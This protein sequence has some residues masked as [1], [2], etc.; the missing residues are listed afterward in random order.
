[1]SIF[2]Q[3]I[4]ILKQEYP[5]LAELVAQPI[6]MDHI[7]IHHATN[8]DVRLLIQSVAGEWVSFHN[9]NSPSDVAKRS[10]EK[11]SALGG[12]LVLLGLGL[13]YL[14]KELVEQ[15]GETS[16]L[17]VYETDLGIFKTALETVDLS[18]VLSDS[19]VRLIVGEEQNISKWISHFMAK[20]G[21]NVKAVKFEP[22]FRLAPNVYERILTDHV[23]NAT[24]NTRSNWAT[25]ERFGNLFAKNCLQSLPG[26]LTT[27]GVSVLRNCFP[28]IPAILVGGG[29][30]LGKNIPVLKRAKGR[31]VIIA[32]D[33][34]LKYLLTRDVVP[35]F[36]V[37]V[38][39]Q[40][41]TF[42]KYEGV[43]IPENVTLVFHP[44]C[45][46]L[47]PQHF[48]GKKFVTDTH[49]GAYAWLKEHWTEKGD[50]ESGVQCQMHLAFNLAQWLGCDPVIFIGQD[51]CFTDNRMHV[52]GGSYLPEDIEE[53]LVNEGS[54][55]TNM[56]GNSLRTSL[57]YLRYKIT[58]ENKIE[59]FYGTVWN[60]SEGG[61]TLTG[62][63][64]L[65]LSDALDRLV[66][67]PE[68]NVSKVLSA[69]PTVKAE[70]NWD[71]LLAEIRGRSRDFFRLQRASRRLTQLLEKIAIHRETTT[72]VNES[73]SR[74]TFQAE[75]LT[76]L[77]PQYHQALELLQ[78][79]DFNLELYMYHDSRTD[80]DKIENELDRLD[81]Q[82]ERG[83]RYY[84]GVRDAATHMHEYLVH[85]TSQLE[86]LRELERETQE[87]I[88]HHDRLSLVTGYV[89]LGLYSQGAECL[90]QL[91]NKLE[92]HSE[93]EKIACLSILIPL[94]L[95]QFE[96]ACQRGQ[97]AKEQFPLNE[98]ISHLYKKA[99]ELQKT[100]M[101]WNSEVMNEKVA[102]V[103]SGLEYG[104]FYYKIEN[105]D[106]AAMHY[107]RV[108]ENQQID[109][110]TKGEAWYRLAQAAKALG[111]TER[112]ISALEESL[113]SNPTNPRVYYDLGVL[114]LH[115]HQ[116]EIA[117]KFFEKGIE[118]SLEDPE[119][120]EA[121]G[122]VWY[123]AG[124]PTEA[125]A[126]VER[127]LIH[128]PGHP[129][130]LHKISKIYQEV[131]QPVH[132]A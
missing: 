116:I 58:I 129:D 27:P 124:Y 61:L 1:V 22:A 49:M 111:D 89:E 56:F 20:T 18:E 96:L 26:I 54:V 120:C 12:V 46:D 16:C 14:A 74:L 35:D 90:P 2:D 11:V 51:L 105:F 3:N 59:G 112:A 23:L 126:F 60:C 110:E 19:R 69:L 44:A 50:I 91:L 24:L 72:S 117:S 87:G 57:V 78:L 39:P 7:K 125:I 100:W 65:Q 47:I 6:S 28:D 9:K 85:L 95:H 94:Q 131:F 97:R 38:D 34:V 130:L 62:A 42:Q 68:I 119:F 36:V 13:G 40:P 98:E 132:S 127:G 31:A 118:V 103:K 66:L 48:P 101:C 86:K 5:D 102:P 41:E 64:T 76:R 8:G 82:I 92:P 45:S 30:S 37:S 80:V 63:Q 107:Q 121:V 67:I 73:M 109:N 15:L 99:D 115:D 17:I 75:R 114:A 71:G 25:A 104:D 84:G 88:E 53:G 123:A 122:A 70:I 55:V 4:K 29:P 32:A 10:A 52:K 113:S 79:I 77:M 81:K 93:Y 43:Q 128:N 108:G 33:T 106:Q 83:L 21:G